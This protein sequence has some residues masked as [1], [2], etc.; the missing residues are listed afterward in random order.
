MF[1]QIMSSHSVKF[2]AKIHYYCREQY[3]CHMESAADDGLKK[4]SN[5]GVLKFFRGYAMILQGIR[6]FD[7]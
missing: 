6:L 4:Y 7:L 1:L 2:Q 5:D 3:F